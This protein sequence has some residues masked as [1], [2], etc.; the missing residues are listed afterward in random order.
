MEESQTSNL[1]HQRELCPLMLAGTGSDVGKSVIATAFCRIFLQDGYHPAPF[2]AQNMAL[3]SYATPEGLEIGRA[4]AVQAEAAGIPCHTDMNPLLL[5]PQS[6]HT[7]QVVLNGRPIGSRDAYDYFRKEGR[8]ELRKSV[9]DAFDRLAARFNPIVMEGA[10]SISE[11]NLRDTDIVN[12]PM[13]RHADADV[14]LVGDIDRGGVFASVYGSIMLQTPEDR[15]RIKG[16]I[17][18][19]FRGDMRLFEEGKRMLEDLCQIPVIGVI[20]YFNHIHVEEE[21]S[22]DLAQKTMHARQGM[23]NVAV[24]LLRHISN[25]TDFNVLERDPRVHLFYTNNT[26]DIRQADII[27]IPG[28]KTTISDLYELR[29]NGVAQAII[30]AHREGATVLGICGGYQMMGNEVCDPQHRE[31]EIERIPGLALLPLST[32]INTTKTTR[33]TRFHLN[34]DTTGEILEGYEIHMGTTTLMDNAD[35]GN[36]SPLTIDEDGLYDGWTDNSRCMGTYIHGILDNQPFIERL[37]RPFEEKIDMKK[38]T[39]DIHA[40]KEQ[41]YNLL[42]D[43]VR[44]Y[45]DMNLVYK[46]LSSR[47][48]CKL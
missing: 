13:A 45:V 5:K 26:D 23:V 17:I 6:D 47:C 27:I 44:K 32:T 46:I 33:Q 24:I 21:D 12:M 38:Q 35:I 43:H 25:F 31:G 39:F 11:I 20:P 42:A 34:D 29:R 9:C 8:E 28:T 18:N 36:I 3:N 10:G 40:Y 7:S 15:Q 37:L 16:I 48:H 19:K 30:K 41:Q 4:Q 14:F 1:K 2:K 22:V